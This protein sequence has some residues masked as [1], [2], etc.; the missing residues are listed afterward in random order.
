MDTLVSSVKLQPYNW[1]AWLKIATCIEGP[2][3]VR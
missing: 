3:E 2:E 1:T